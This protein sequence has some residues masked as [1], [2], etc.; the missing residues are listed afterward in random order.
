MQGSQAK[1]SKHVPESVLRLPSLCALYLPTSYLLS[2]CGA[3]LELFVAGLLS[4][5]IKAVCNSEHPDSSLSL[6]TSLLSCTRV[7]IISGR[8]SCL[9]CSGL[10]SQHLEQSLLGTDTPQVWRVLSKT[11]KFIPGYRGLGF[12]AALLLSLGI[13]S[14]LLLLINIFTPSFL[15]Q[16][17]GGYCLFFLT[18]F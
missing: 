12:Q 10:F 4:G 6:G 7:S 8:H 11:N 2:F 9:F 18:G 16:I 1:T 13:S 17:E 3:L 15:E 5:F 14:A